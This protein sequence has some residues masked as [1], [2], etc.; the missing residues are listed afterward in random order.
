[1][2]TWA[3]GDVQGCATTLDRLLARIAFDP[4]RDRLWLV[5]DLVNRGRRSADVLRR[6]RAFGDA[7]VVVL[8]NHDL[9]LIARALG[10]AE[11]KRRDTLDDVLAAP[12]CAALIDWL[13]AR[14]LVHRD[15][16]RVLVHAGLLPSWTADDAAE[17]ARAL[18]ATLRGPRAGELLAGLARP[19]ATWDQRPATAL[20]AMTRVR[21]VQGGAMVL[22][23]DGPPGDDGAPAGAAPWFDAPERRWRGQVVFG[24]WSA[25]GLTLRADAIGLDTGCVWGRALTA[26]NADDGA[27]IQEPAAAEDLAR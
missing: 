26:W 8:G 12:D 20:Y 6:V 4:A 3:I 27:V 5:G 22:D 21:L 9:H 7:A 1:M 13:R 18:E 19:S 16:S 24:H 14:P 15:K 23:Y 17:W 11:R 2:A 10:V 25:L